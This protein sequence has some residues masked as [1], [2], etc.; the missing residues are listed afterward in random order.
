VVIL[1]FMNTGRC[2][3]VLSDVTLP[4]GRV[5][6]L[7]IRD[8][9]VCHTGSP[10]Q[11]DEK[12]SCRSYAVLPAAVDMHVHMRGGIQSEKE[13]WKSGSQSALAG[14]V[15]VVVDQPNTIPPIVTAGIFRSKLAEARSQAS[16]G[17]A[18]N[19]GVTEGNDLE[20][21]WREGSMAFGEIF[22]APSSFA[23]GISPAALS[24]AL[25]TIGSLGALATLHAEEV[26]AGIPTD[27]TE[28][29]RLR[30]P[31][32]EQKVVEELVRSYGGL[33]R[34]HF[35]HLSIAGAVRSAGTASAE[36][37]PHHLFLS[38]ERGGEGGFLKVNPP[39]RPE[40]ERRELWGMWDRIDVIASDHAPHTLEE[41]KK[42]FAEAP[43]GIPG[44]ETMLPLLMASCLSGRIS[45]LSVMEKTS[46]NP[47]KI[48]GIHPAGFQPGMRADFALYGKET[49]TIC[50]DEL[51]SRARWTP[52]EGMKGL[53]PDRVIMA[54]S[55]AW[56][57]GEFHQG[58]GRWYAGRGYHQS[59]RI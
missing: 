2:D 45:R 55:P 30:T 14:G 9:L 36:V 58:T 19:G 34:L 13:D 59:S 47:A 37:T 7:S 46:W 29:N 38:C 23:N 31:D 44:V 49:V 42:S 15:T 27:A 48:L 6:D 57:R 24:A 22:V 41:K 1:S 33:C 8:G 18:L 53:F 50:A 10:L 51:H 25:S 43:P 56:D 5:A 21:L 16:C 3:L 4:D 28:H 40:K 11:S 52:Y 20:E 26:K 32:G 54:G 12:L 17:F 39:L 35:C